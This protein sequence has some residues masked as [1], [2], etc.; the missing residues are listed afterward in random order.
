MPVK[1]PRSFVMSLALVALAAAQSSPACA[2]LVLSR[3]IVELTPAEFQRSDIELW[4]NG[5]DRAFVEIDPREIIAPGTPAQSSRKDPDPEK[6]GLLVSPERIILEPGQRRLLR[7]ASLG[8]SDR[9]RVY[10]V[11]VKPVVGELASQTSGLKLLVGYDVLVLVRPARAMPHVS[12]SRS[13]PQLSLK[14]DGNVSVEL[15]DGRACDQS[16]H[17]CSDLPAARLYAGAEKTVNVEGASKI[18]YDL[19]V[20]SKLIAVEF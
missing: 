16:M 1:L 5:P 6:L 14:N 20:G 10:R 17:N 3:M 18:H 7:I 11:T 9:E 12:A 13:G 8:T 4:N 2:E 15:V 19:K